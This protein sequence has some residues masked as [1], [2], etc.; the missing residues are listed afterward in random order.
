MNMYRKVRTTPG[1]VND[2]AAFQA[3]VAAGNFHAMAGTA[4]Q[5]VMDVYECTK[6][7]AYKEIRQIVCALTSQHYSRSII[8]NNNVPADEYGIVIEE[9]GWYVKLQVNLD[10]GEAEVCSCH[11]PK[12]DMMTKGGLIPASDPNGR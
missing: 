9:I 2:L 11:P 1:P 10:D 12:R 5:P 8:M 4:L 6:K 7:E 3:L